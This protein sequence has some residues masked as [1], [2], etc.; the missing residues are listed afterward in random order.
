MIARSLKALLDL[1]RWE[2]ALIASLGVLF[3]AWWVGW[4][5][6]RSIAFA[7]VAALPLTAAA[8]AWNDIADIAIDRRAHPSRPLPSGRLTVATARRFAAFAAFAGVV[9]ASGADAQLGILTVV[10][11]ALMY[12]YSNGIKRAGLAG[13][14]TVAVLASLPFLY[15]GWAA[16]RPSKALVLVAIAAPLHFAREIAKDIED[17]PADA[18]SRDTLPVTGGSEVA[19]AVLVASL[20]VFL[21]L[22]IPY[23]VARPPLAVALL[24]AAGLVAYA[25][26]C[27]VKGRRGSPLVFKIAMLCAMGAFVVVHH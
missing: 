18:G 4:G 17:A 23:V 25:G 20:I 13:N 14:V 16:G 15:G 3:G 6:E 22:L 10:V 21:L 5:S 24:P 11:V 19:A 7:I 27:V 2:N 12:A 26:W 8:N 1:A 9:L